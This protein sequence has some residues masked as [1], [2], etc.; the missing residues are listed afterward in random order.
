MPFSQTI[1]NPRKALHGDVDTWKIKQH[2]GGDELTLRDG[3]SV[4]RGKY[5][6]V[7]PLAF[8]LL[9]RCYAQYGSAK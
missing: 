3:A 7:N 6:R 5:W 2:D 1:E 4:C 9:P 8:S